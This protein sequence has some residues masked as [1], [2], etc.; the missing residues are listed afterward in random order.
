MKSIL[1]VLLL[2]AAAV[3]QTTNP[4]KDCYEA[5]LR[6]YPPAVNGIVFW[7]HYDARTQICW[8]RTQQDWKDELSGEY[9]E[10]D[11][12]GNLYEMQSK[13]MFLGPR[14]ADLK[15]GLDSC[16]VNKVKCNSLEEWFSLAEKQYPDL[17]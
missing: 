7:N 4:Q 12:I 8:V 10:W 11:T 13:A 2:T 5:A 14:F 1:F 3:G 6:S 16:S 17:F 15:P 9:R